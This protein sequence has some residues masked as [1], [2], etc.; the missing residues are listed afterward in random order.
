L[1]FVTPEMFGAVGDGDSENPT[2]DT[3]AI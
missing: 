2:D 1:L 3:I